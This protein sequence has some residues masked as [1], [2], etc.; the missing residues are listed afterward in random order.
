VLDLLVR[1][2][3]NGQIA[4]TLGI[5][6]DGAKWHVSEIITRLGVDSRDEAAEYWRERNGLRMRFS[7]F[8]GGLFSGTGLKVAG[9][10]AAT[11]AVGVAVVFALMVVLSRGEG[12][13]EGVLSPPPPADNGANPDPATPPSTT[14][15]PA[16]TGES[17]DGVAVK[18]LTVGAPLSLPKDVVFFYMPRTYATDGG[19]IRLHRAYTD[20]TG[21]LRAEP[22]FTGEL[23]KAYSFAIDTSRGAIGV[24]VCAQGYCGGVGEPS[25]D[26]RAAAY[27]S[28]DG[29][30]SFKKLGE[31][32]RGAF[33]NGIVG[34]EVLVTRYAESVTTHALFPSGNLVKPPA[35]R[36]YPVQVAGGIVWQGTNAEIYSSAGQLLSPAQSYGLSTGSLPLVNAAA[37]QS[38]K[39]WM[40]QPASAQDPGQQYVGVYDG[41]QLVDAYHWEGR[42]LRAVA[43]LSDTLLLGNFYPPQSGFGEFPAVLI[44]LASGEIRP[45][46]DLSAAVTKGHPFVL[47]ASVGPV[48]RV[49][50]SGDCLNVRETASTTATSLGCFKDGV[51]LKDRGK[52]E[53]AGGISWQAVGTPDGREG[54]ASSEFL[55]K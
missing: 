13:E 34:E 39:T 47:G 51:L 8:L 22:L 15:P 31:L 24:G 4:E 36:S 28:T 43:K 37:S 1:G 52:T 11:A 21:N 27:L 53:Q 20:A 50:T 12:E 5:S 9:G 7:R 38:I 42:E 19:A 55:A 23:E 26:A 29:G 25:P 3:T 46:S 41:S 10:V 35:D 30:V 17:I 6:L 40:K 33:V 32:P 49:A 16:L 18:A 2:R 44:D 45:L 14:K 48:L 54:W